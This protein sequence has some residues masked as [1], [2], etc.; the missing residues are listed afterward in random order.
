MIGL[1]LSLNTPMKNSN[2]FETKLNNC[3]NMLKLSQLKYDPTD[4]ASTNMQLDG[5]VEDDE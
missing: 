5:E 3:S 2:I 1:N 4:K